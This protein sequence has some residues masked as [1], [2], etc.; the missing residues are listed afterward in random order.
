MGELDEIE[1]EDSQSS[2]KEHE[3]RIAS[4]HKQAE[5]TKGRALA[6][7]KANRI[8]EAK[9]ALKQFKL[10]EAQAA[11]EEAMLKA[12]MAA[13]RP[14]KASAA[15]RAREEAEEGEDMVVDEG[16]LD[17][18][19]LL[20]EL[21]EVQKG[22]ARVKVPGRSQASAGVSSK[23]QPAAAEIDFDYDAIVSMTVMQY[24]LEEAKKARDQDLAGK[25]EMMV[26]VRP[27]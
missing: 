17:D 20:Q 16:D 7:K 9:E 4:L 10:L 15:A 2:L 18:P 1:G 11:S 12:H 27:K 21:A 23:A 14:S 19:E 8:E 24:E 22:T 13:H 25:L 6:L 5:A 3:G 26:T